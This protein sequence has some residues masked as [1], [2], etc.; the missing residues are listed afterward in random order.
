MMLYS[1]WGLGAPM[2]RGWRRMEHFAGRGAEPTKAGHVGPTSWIWSCAP[3]PDLFPTTLAASRRAEQTPQTQDFLQAPSQ[4]ASLTVCPQLPRDGE[5]PMP[6]ALA[7]F[8]VLKCWFPPLGPHCLSQPLCV[9][10]QDTPQTGTPSLC[11]ELPVKARQPRVRALSTSFGTR[12]DL[13]KPEPDL[14]SPRFTTSSSACRF[15]CQNQ[16][17]WQS[18]NLEARLPPQ[19]T[20]HF[21]GFDAAVVI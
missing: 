10:G 14:E 19:K 13:C 15:A 8:S 6:A 1:G 11:L 12:R 16:F 21:H 3:K 4:P 7:L 20:C 9:A 17:P 5:I 2:R 18:A